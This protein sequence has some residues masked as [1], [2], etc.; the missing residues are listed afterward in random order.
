MGVSQNT[1][2]QWENGA[3][4]P[5]VISLKKMAQI[6]DCST[7]MLLEDIETNERTDD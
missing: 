3:R 4:I 2:S 7:D 6:L 5:N 1:I